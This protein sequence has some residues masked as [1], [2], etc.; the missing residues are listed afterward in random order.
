MK[1]VRVVEETATVRTLFFDHSFV[2]I[3][4]Q[5]VGL[6]PWRGWDPHGSFCTGFNHRSDCR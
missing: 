4:G 1:I 5:F 3:P 2:C 6:G